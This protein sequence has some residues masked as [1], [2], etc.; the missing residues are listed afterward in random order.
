L[1]CAIAILV[2]VS[3]V[4]Q[5][6]TPKPAAILHTEGGVWVN[7]YE[8]RD[9]SAVF[10]GDL[11]ETKTGFSANLSI[12]G[13]TVVIG[14]E[15]VTKFQGDFLELDHGSVSVG[16]SKSFRVH[17]N[18]I[19]VVPVLNEWTQYDVTDVNRTVQVAAHKDDVNVE[20]EMGRGK[21]AADK[22]A[23]QRAS[24]HQGEQHSYDETGICGAPGIVNAG[25]PLS[26]KWIAIEAGAG[27]GVLCALVCRG[28]GGSKKP[29][30]SEWTP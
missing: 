8:A 6:T 21:P 15:S 30:I 20:H 24:V 2:P 4:G 9:S 10:P 12:E 5:D 23:P 14:Q 27:G 16:T 17:V 29:S 28:S 22:A 11:V 18:C 26:P 19:R 1:C 3:L 13:S 25:G 7:G